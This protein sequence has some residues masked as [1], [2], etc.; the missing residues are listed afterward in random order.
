MTGQVPGFAYTINQNQIMYSMGVRGFADEANRIPFT[1]VMRM[2]IASV[3]KT[4][5]AAAVLKILARKPGAN[6]DSKISRYLPSGWVRGPN[7]D[8]LTFRH[9]LT[10]KSGFIQSG[11]NDEYGA[12]RSMIEGGINKAALGNHYEYKNANYSLFRVILPILAGKKDK[13][14]IDAFGAA[15]FYSWV[16]HEEIFKPMGIP[17]AFVFQLPDSP[18]KYYNCVSDV[19]G[20]GGDY[21][22]RSGAYGWHL[23][24]FDLAAFMAHLRY[25]NDILAPV[26]RKQMDDGLLGWENEHGSANGEHGT[27]LYHSGGW[28]AGDDP[29]P[30]LRTCIMKYAD[31][32][33][34][35]SL[36]MNCVDHP[37]PNIASPR[38]LLR[39]IFDNSWE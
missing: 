29:A 39:I 9:L 27:Y 25:N 31:T 36:L 13:S 35:V 6:I 4:I 22:M 28:H 20:G 30:G 12:L 37:N 18:M 32:K 5:T 21:R 7:V 8:L 2:H 14:Q 34:E 11:G 16:I 19:T 15:V 1:P 3:S 23:S 26:T 38:K 17:D 10:H 33:V 24:A